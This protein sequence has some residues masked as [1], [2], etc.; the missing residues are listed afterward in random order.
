MVQRELPAR[1]ISGTLPPTVHQAPWHQQQ[2]VL[3]KPNARFAK[4]NVPHGEDPQ[5][6]ATGQ[7]SMGQ[8]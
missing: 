7:A 8:E 3:A 2:F 4:K 1:P 6:T 5:T